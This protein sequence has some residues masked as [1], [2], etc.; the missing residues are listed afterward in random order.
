MAISMTVNAILKHKVDNKSVLASE[1]ASR[2]TVSR[3]DIEVQSKNLISEHRNRSYIG[4]SSLASTPFGARFSIH[5]CFIGTRHSF[6]LRN[7]ATTRAIVTC[8][9][10]L[11]L[12]TAKKRVYVRSSTPRR[13][14]SGPP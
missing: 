11:L 1:M 12:S 13:R 5:D 9:K 4:S 14:G 8:A 10:M 3:S 6:K 7:D 2:V